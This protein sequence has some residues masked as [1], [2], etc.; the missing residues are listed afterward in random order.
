MC[1]NCLLVVLYCCCHSCCGA[2]DCGKWC[3]IVPIV[4][5]GLICATIV[6]CALKNG[7]YSSQ[8]KIRREELDLQRERMAPRKNDESASNECNSGNESAPTKKEEKENSL[9]KKSSEKND[10][11]K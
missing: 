7:K 8:V 10:S 4:V 1:E 11:A 6:I 9:K 3:V 5:V 2:N